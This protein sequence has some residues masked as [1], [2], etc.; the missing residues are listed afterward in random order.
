MINKRR[1]AD[2]QNKIERMSGERLAAG[3]L[4][5]IVEKG[6]KQDKKEMK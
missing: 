3:A 6:R 5:Q 1:E 4:N 2:L